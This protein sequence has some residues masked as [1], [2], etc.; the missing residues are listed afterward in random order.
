MHRWTEPFIPRR[1]RIDWS[2]GCFAKRVGSERRLDKRSTGTYYRPVG[3]LNDFHQ[4]PPL[5]RSRTRESLV[6]CSWQISQSLTTSAI[7]KEH[8]VQLD[9]LAIL[10]RW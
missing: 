4:T 8:Q 9:Y 3:R 5:H 7:C 6:R 2:I 10:F 1:S